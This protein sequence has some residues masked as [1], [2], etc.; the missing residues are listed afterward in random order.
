M[1]AAFNPWETGDMRLCLFL[2]GLTL[3]TTAGCVNSGERRHKEPSAG[4]DHG[5]HPGDLDHGD[6][7]QH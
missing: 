4:V 2:V 1:A 3:L 6:T 5:E 7:Q